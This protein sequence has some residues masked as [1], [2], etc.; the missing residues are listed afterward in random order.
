MTA[1]IGAAYGG[2]ETYSSKDRQMETPCPSWYADNEWNVGV[3]GVYAPT[4]NDYRDDEY[5]GVDHAWGGA[6][7]VKYFFHRYFGVG[8][9][10]F[11]L[12]LNADN[13]RNFGDD[14]N[15][16]DFAGGALGTFTL[17]YPIP[18]TRFAPYT[19]AGLGFISGG[20]GNTF[21][22]QNTAGGFFL[23]RR[24]DSNAHLLAQYGVGFEIRVTQHIGWT[25]DVSYN[26]IFSGTHNDFLQVRT[27][28][29][30]AF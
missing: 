26:Q 16:N 29:N 7:D 15:T 11:G 3:S 1:L 23:D 14:D 27:G 18:C 19:W 5:L 17:R 8:V 10:G 2:S 6:L 30:F 9:Q 4:T 13:I 20:G 28:L 22:N 12:V 24:G 25:N 21:V